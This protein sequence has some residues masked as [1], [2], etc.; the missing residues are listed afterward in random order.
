MYELGISSSSVKYRQRLKCRARGHTKPVGGVAY[1][2]LS[3]AVTQGLFL[4]LWKMD[5]FLGNSDFFYIR[6]FLYYYT[7]QRAGRFILYLG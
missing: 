4:Q 6:F 3:C 2:S 7:E 1:L 5:I